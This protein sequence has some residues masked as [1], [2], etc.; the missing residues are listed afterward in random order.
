MSALGCWVEEL[1]KPSGRDRLYLSGKR[2]CGVETMKP[3]R[4]SGQAIPWSSERTKVTPLLLLLLGEKILNP[5]RL[6]K[7]TVKQDVKGQSE[8][9]DCVAKDGPGKKG[10]QRKSLYI[11]VAWR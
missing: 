9:S 7:L 4:T 2:G 1:K 11:C 8:V 3:A 5:A 6:P 10:T